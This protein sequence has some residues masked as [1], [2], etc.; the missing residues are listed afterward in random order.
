MKLAMLLTLATVAACGS[1]VAGTLPRAGAED[2]PPVRVAQAQA[3][4]PPVGRAQRLREADEALRAANAAL[5][6]ARKQL[7]LGK[8]PLPGERTGMVNGM[9]RLNETY[10]ARQ[11][12]NEAAVKEAEARRDAAL[13]ARN[14]ARF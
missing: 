13:A 4:T 2:V 14:A 12:A 8:E 3:E 11:A 5:A 10:W 6:Q 1:A 9:S 7:E